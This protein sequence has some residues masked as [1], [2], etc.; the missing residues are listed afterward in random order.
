MTEHEELNPH[1]SAE[2]VARVQAAIDWRQAPIWCAAY[3]V[4]CVDHGDSTV[5]DS[6]SPVPQIEVGGC[7]VMHESAK[8]YTAPSF[9]IDCLEPGQS[10]IIRRPGHEYDAMACFLLNT[11]FAHANILNL[12]RDELVEAPDADYRRPPH[13]KHTVMAGAIMLGLARDRSF[14]P[15]AAGVHSGG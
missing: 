4:V 12:A 3:I 7:W 6:G 11:Y 2:T 9:G 5:D 1:L 14:H 10:C 13:P 15:A 8:R